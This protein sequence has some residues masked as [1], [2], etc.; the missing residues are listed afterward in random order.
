MESAELLQSI[1]SRLSN[2]V[3]DPCPSFVDKVKRFRD[4]GYTRIEM[5]VY[6][7][8]LF[9][10]ALYRY[11]LQSFI[12]SSLQACPTFQVPLRDQWHL[13]AD[14]LNHV[15]ALYEEST[16]CFAYCHWWNSLTKR[17]QGL[18][19]SN[20][21]KE[22]V[23]SLLGNYSFNER[24]IHCFYLTSEKV[25][26][27]H[28]VYKRPDGCDAMTLVPG[29]SN[30]LFPSRKGLHINVKFEEIGID[31]HKGIYIEWPEE[32]LRKYRREAVANVNLV[33]NVFD[34]S[35]IQDALP[36]QLLTNNEI[37]R[38]SQ[39]DPDYKVLT[40]GRSYIAFQY[41]FGLFR[42]KQYLCLTLDN[43]LMVRCS[44]AMRDV[45]E[46]KLAEGNRFQFQVISI[47]TRRGVRHVNCQ[48]A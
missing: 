43:D 2:L 13:I 9:P 44:E 33:Q 3:A 4:L 10:F 40:E 8:D 30:S 42:G 32:R 29:M 11:E 22:L 1:G 47:T 39:Y 20:V 23:P 17:K 6:G 12:A 34:M 15:V 28:E 21:P 38:A 48:L 25:I 41:G 27:R 18:I 16:Q 7:K 46:P 19:K 14:Q 24:L 5:T 31:T 45:L 26:D 36:S 35:D 37:V